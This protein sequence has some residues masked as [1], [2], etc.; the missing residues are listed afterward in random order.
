MGIQLA[1]R[2]LLRRRRWRARY[3]CSLLELAEEL[4]VSP[5][6]IR[7]QVG[8]RIHIDSPALG[9]SGRFRLVSV[10][11]S[12]DTSRVEVMLESVGDPLTT[13]RAAAQTLFVHETGQRVGSA[14]P[15]AV[16]YYRAVEV[17]AA[18]LVANTP[19]D[20]ERISESS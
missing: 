19:I 7:A 11:W 5:A 18:G 6:L 10:E 16:G 1:N 12:T 14:P 3:T 20:V 17:S 13:Q 4:K 8:G 2:E 15:A 9:V